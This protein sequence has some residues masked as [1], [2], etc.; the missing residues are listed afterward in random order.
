MDQILKGRDTAIDDVD[1]LLKT[2][3][4]V[5]S[6]EA[7]DKTVGSS[8]VLEIADVTEWDVGVITI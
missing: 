1:V 4:D 2:S 6:M 5:V 3:V 8:I 7:E